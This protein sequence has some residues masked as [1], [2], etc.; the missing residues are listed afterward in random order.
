MILR[1][2]ILICVLQILLYILIDQLNIKYAKG[3]ILF[4]ILYA[5][6]F[7][8]PGYFIPAPKPGGV[9]CGMPMMAIT[10]G[11]WIFGGG[12]TLLTHYIYSIIA[13]AKHR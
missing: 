11:F 13:G 9:N 3:L 5:H 7:V 8:L 10:L 2:I 1:L 6:I 12:V 4:A